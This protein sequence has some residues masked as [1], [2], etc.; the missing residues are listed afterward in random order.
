MSISIADFSRHIEIT[1]QGNLNIIPKTSASV[2]SS[3]NDVGINY[4][5]SGYSNQ[6]FSG[7][8]TAVNGRRVVEIDRQNAL[9][10]YNGWLQHYGLPAQQ[11]GQV[12]SDCTFYPLGRQLAA[13]DIPSSPS[14][15]PD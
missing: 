13:R 12:I 9:Q 14:P 11:P 6:P 4:F 8:V 15:A 1:K 7:T 3:N 5:S 2:Y 10:V